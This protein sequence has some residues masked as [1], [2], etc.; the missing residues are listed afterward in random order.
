[1]FER[2]AQGPYPDKLSLLY[3]LLITAKNLSQAERALQRAHLTPSERNRF[4]KEFG[5]DYLQRIQHI[6][7]D[8]LSSA[9]RPP[10]A[11]WIKSYVQDL[12]PESISWGSSA[13][14]SFLRFLSSDGMWLY[15]PPD[16]QLDIQRWS[17]LLN[18]IGRPSTKKTDIVALGN[19]L[20]RLERSPEL[21]QRL[22]EAFASCIDSE[23]ELSSLI[24]MISTWTPFITKLDLIQMLYAMAESIR[25]NLADAGEKQLMKARLEVYIR[26]VLCFDA[27]YELSAAEEKLFIQ[28]FLHLLLQSADVETLMRL[29][30]RSKKWPEK[31]SGKWQLYMPVSARRVGIPRSSEEELGKINAIGNGT[32]LSEATTYPQQTFFPSASPGRGTSK[33]Q[34]VFTWLKGLF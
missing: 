13:A 33:E 18:F 3:S 7:K 34:N 17:T 10:L 11:D 22:A 12:N 20:R 15:L 5:K 16:I 32:L 25:N 28:T 29:N 8:Y 23:T 27:V 1:V 26:F 30:I 6:N 31:L 21:G 14:L 4:L 2:I 19:V 9:P 24:S